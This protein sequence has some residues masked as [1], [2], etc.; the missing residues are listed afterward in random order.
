MSLWTQDQNALDNS[1]YS[2]FLSFFNQWGWPNSLAEPEVI[3]HGLRVAAFAVNLGER[4]GLN[5]EELI[6]L[7]RCALLH[8]VGKMSIPASILTKPGPL[9]SLERKMVET[10]P[11]H[12]ALSL[13]KIGFDQT[14][15]QIVRC[16]HEKWDGSGYP[17]GLSRD[18]IPLLARL[19]TLADVW[20]ALTHDRPYRNA[21]S[22]AET[23]RYIE[24]ESGKHFD[25]YLV[26]VL[27]Q[28]FSRK[29]T[30]PRAKYN[31]FAI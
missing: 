4:I 2:G 11:D 19:I 10:H 7:R 23:L 16:H 29:K 17:L 25:P 28:I 18:N 22:Q 5:E 12:G 9:N 8:D 1:A 21:W 20:D 3:D 26:E 31:D 30:L 13:A 14:A 24:K 6:C 15:V 27:W